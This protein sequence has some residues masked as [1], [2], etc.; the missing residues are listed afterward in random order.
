M[1][2]LA[3]MQHRKSALS[4]LVFVVAALAV[5]GHLCGADDLPVVTGAAPSENHADADGD[6]HE[7]LHAA[8]CYAVAPAPSASL[9][10]PG[11]CTPPV[12]VYT[13]IAVVARAIHA[14]APYASPPLFLLHAALL[15]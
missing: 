5:A 2:G 6:A 9:S 15:I 7:T 12:A 10:A 13:G 14:P 4:W 11:V 8:S 1:Y 3:T